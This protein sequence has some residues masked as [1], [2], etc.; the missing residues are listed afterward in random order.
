M[1]SIIDDVLVRQGVELWIKRDD[2]LHPIISGNKWRKLKYTLDHA[3]QL[4][5]AGLV[6]MGGAYSNHLHALAYAGKC[7]EV[8]TLGWIRGE[9]PDTLNPTVSDL[10]R[11]GMQLSFVSR[12]EYRQL[13]Q[14]Q[15]YDSLPDWSDGHYWLPEGGAGALALR[16]V[17]EIIDEIDMPYDV[18]VVACGTATTLAGLITAAPSDK[19]VLGIAALKG[20]AFLRDDVNRLLSGCCEATTPSWDMLLDYHHGGFAR[21]TPALLSFIHEMRL[22]HQLPLEFVYTAK[23]LYAIYDLLQQGYFQS[24][25]RIVMIHTGGLQGAR[26]SA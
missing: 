26:G 5:V 13:R 22:R 10:Q 7:L 4:G 2:L 1:M 3:L 20:A 11:W 17:A 6:S 21:T 14:F 16:G 15:R 24:G 12:Q 19:K 9:R 18:L 8:P 23:A 25:Q